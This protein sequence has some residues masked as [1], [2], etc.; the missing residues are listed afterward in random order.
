MYYFLIAKLNIGTGRLQSPYLE[1]QNKAWPYFDLDNILKYLK[2]HICW[3]FTIEHLTACPLFHLPPALI[4]IPPFALTVKHTHTYTSTRKQLIIWIFLKQI[5]ITGKTEGIYNTHTQCEIIYIK[6]QRM[7]AKQKLPG[8]VNNVALATCPP[9]WFS[10][11]HS[12][13]ANYILH[14]YISL[15]L[16]LPRSLVLSAKRQI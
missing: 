16:S 4:I 12:L 8:C 13:S 15:L 14:I 2:S 11:C 7:R 10:S 3:Q 6:N 9:S 5:N 1:P